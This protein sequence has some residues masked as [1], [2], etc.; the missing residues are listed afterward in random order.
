LDRCLD[1]VNRLAD[2]VK[3]ALLQALSEGI[4]FLVREILIRFFRELLGA[5]QTTG[6]VQTGAD[7]RMIAQV[8]VD[9]RFADIGDRVI[10]G[11]N[12][13]FLPMNSP[14]PTSRRARAMRR[15]IRAWR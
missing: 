6:V 13:F 4:I 1:I 2:V 10:D 5:V 7:R 12:C 15:S 14:P 11:A 3:E 9:G 8:F